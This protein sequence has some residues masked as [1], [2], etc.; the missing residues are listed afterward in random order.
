MWPFW[1]ITDAWQASGKA[2]RSTGKAT[3]L[4]I[5]VSSYSSLREKAIAQY[6]LYGRSTEFSITLT[7]L[8]SSEHC[9]DLEVFCQ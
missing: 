5:Q 6:Q 8:R 4:M 3:I 7:H 9:H 2:L 1:S